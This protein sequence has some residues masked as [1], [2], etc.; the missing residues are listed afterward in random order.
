MP[1]IRA[2]F[3]NQSGASAIEYSMFAACI[4]AAIIAIGP[5]LGSDFQAGWT[6]LAVKL[7]SSVPQ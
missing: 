4:A 6:N 3:R 5:Q 7:R 2:F 1:L